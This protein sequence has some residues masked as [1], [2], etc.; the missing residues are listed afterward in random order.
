MFGLRL[1]TLA[2]HL[3]AF[4]EISYNFW[5]APYIYLNITTSVYFGNSPHPILGIKVENKIL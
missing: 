3:K 1:A 2:Y 5:R 4:Q